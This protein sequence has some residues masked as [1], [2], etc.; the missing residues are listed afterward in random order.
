MP[1]DEV[2]P[3]T[4]ARGSCRAAVRSRC[5]GYRSAT[6]VDGLPIIFFHFS[7]LKRISAFLW[8]TSHLRFGAPMD[9][10]VRS[11]LYAPYFA[12]LLAGETSV[13]R[14]IAEPVDA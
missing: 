12:D 5:R 13:R 4:R 7:G 8:R 11:L 2:P 3:Y 10:Q 9:R 1:P 6:T 14:H